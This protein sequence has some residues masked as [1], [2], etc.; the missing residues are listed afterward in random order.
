[1]RRVRARAPLAQRKRF[2]S[3]FKELR[4]AKDHREAEILDVC[5]FYLFRE[6]ATPYNA[7]K[8]AESL[9][10]WEI[11]TVVN[12]LE[13]RIHRPHD[14]GLWITDPSTVSKKELKEAMENIKKVAES[15][16]K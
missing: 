9:T 1:M 8:V 14:L 15:L 11:D 13:G 10:S 12:G 4:A 6:S 2:Y 16:E 3:A 5:W 7:R